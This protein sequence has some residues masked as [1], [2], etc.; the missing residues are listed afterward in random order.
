MKKKIITTIILLVI[1][2]SPL[3][4][5][6]I[7]ACLEPDI[8][9]N[10]AMIEMFAMICVVALLDILYGILAQ[11]ISNK[12]MNK[13]SEEF[14]RLMDQT[15]N[16]YSQ[17]ILDEHMYRKIMG[18]SKED[19][20]K[21]DSWAIYVFGHYILFQVNLVACFVFRDVMPPYFLLLILV[22]SI[23]VISLIILQRVF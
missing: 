4:Y 10:N 23:I 17:M 16:L 12:D 15:D 5:K 14:E 6:A 19:K 3:V 11:K 8:I 21:D 22:L 20:L 1:F 2:Y 9:S 13:Y 7:T 18:S